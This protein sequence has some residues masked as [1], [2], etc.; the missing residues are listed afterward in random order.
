[1]EEYEKYNYFSMDITLNKVGYDF[2]DIES[3]FEEP[4]CMSYHTKIG[5][6][7]HPS[8]VGHSLIDLQLIFNFILTGASTVIVSKI[9]SDLYDWT[10]KSLSKVLAKKNDFDDSRIAFVFKDFTIIVSAHNKDD[11]LK[12]VKNVDVIVEHLKTKTFD[13]KYTH[14]DFEDL[15]TLQIHKKD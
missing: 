3:L 12:V 10:K 1:M 2:Y 14:I 4:F 13:K 11:I 8:A 7:W 6:E 9:A 5:F 15:N